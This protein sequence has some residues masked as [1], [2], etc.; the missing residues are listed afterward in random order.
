MNTAEV[1]RGWRWL[2]TLTAMGIAALAGA[3]NVAGQLP[4]NQAESLPPSTGKLYGQF[5]YSG[6]NLARLQT[7]T[8][9]AVLFVARASATRIYRA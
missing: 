4:D 6:G 8:Q 5:D 2:I 1:P 3:A 7:Y 9:R